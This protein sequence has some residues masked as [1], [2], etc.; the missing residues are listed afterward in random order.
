LH[1]KCTRKC[2]YEARKNRN[3]QDQKGT[4]VQVIL[5][6]DTL[7][8][9]ARLISEIFNVQGP[10]VVKHIN[11]IYASGELDRVSTCSILEQVAFDGKLRTMNFYNLDVI[12]SVGYKIK[13]SK[14]TQF[15]QWATKRLKEYCYLVFI[16][17]NKHNTEDVY[18]QS[19]WGISSAG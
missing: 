19:D 9:D 17:L 18:L 8:L 3:F 14:A 10:A 11:N 12:I 5:E 2:N 4:D 13:S 7:W 15:R 1:T 6:N 16:T